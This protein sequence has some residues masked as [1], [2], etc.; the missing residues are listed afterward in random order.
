MSQAGD[1]AEGLNWKEVR[2][3]EEGACLRKL[4]VKMGELGVHTGAGWPQS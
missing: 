4:R 2:N 3:G 1:D